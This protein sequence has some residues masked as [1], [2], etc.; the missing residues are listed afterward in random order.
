IAQRKDRRGI[1]RFVR[2]FGPW[3]DHPH[4]EA[5][6]ASQ[7]RGYNVAIGDV[8][9]SPD[10]ARNASGAA[11]RWR[12]ID[13]K[14]KLTEVAIVDCS[15]HWSNIIDRNDADPHLFEISRRS[16]KMRKD[17][18]AHQGRA[19]RW[20]CPAHVDDLPTTRFY[21]ARAP[22]AAQQY[23]TTSSSRRP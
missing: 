8:E 9:T 17:N 1:G 14:A 22:S 5:L 6:L 12:R 13:F 4:I 15:K 10:E 16:A 20:K 3:R 19:D 7:E 11:C 2:E 23:R 21:P 18:Q